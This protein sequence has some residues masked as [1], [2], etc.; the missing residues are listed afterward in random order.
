MKR[1]LISVVLL[2]AAVVSAGGIALAAAESVSTVPAPARVADFRFSTTTAST[3]T[4]PIPRLV[5]VPTTVDDHGRHDA[6]SLD[7]HGRH[8]G[9]DDHGRHDAPSLD[10]HGRRGGGDDEGESGR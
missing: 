7:D 3:T 10:D 2:G 5:V 9:S 4:A 6:P 8:R 1:S